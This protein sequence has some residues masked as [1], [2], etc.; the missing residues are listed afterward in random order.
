[1]LFRTALSGFLSAGLEEG[2]Y[3]ERAVVRLTRML[4]ADNAK[5]AYQL[6]DQM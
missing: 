3:S 5:R 6:A 2:L 4:C 1:M